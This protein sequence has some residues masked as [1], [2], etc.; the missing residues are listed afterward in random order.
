MDNKDYR[1]DIVLDIIEHPDKYTSAQLNEILSDPETHEI[2]N[3][4]C[5][6]DSAIE[7]DKTVDVDA[8]WEKF[9]QEHKIRKR[10]PFVWRGSRAASIAII[11][12]TSI[13]AIA[14]GITITVAVKDRSPKPTVEATSNANP[15]ST[16][17]PDGS[18]QESKDSISI[19]T[20]PV[21][22][23]DDAFEDIMK[24]I[25]ATYG[26]DITFNNKEAA[27]LHLYYRLDPSLTIDEVISQLNTFEQI[28]I[29]HNGNTLTID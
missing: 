4:L 28:N 7:S 10:R 21:M 9:A 14:A 3:L 25:S 16:A 24:A 23:E 20:E 22:F 12:C 17:I 19:A 11:V 1:Y 6:T 26:V 18:V 2:Y 13:V 27:S 8:E 5:K 15:T 29:R